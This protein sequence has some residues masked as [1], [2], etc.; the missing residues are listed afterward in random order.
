MAILIGQQRLMGH[1]LLDIPDSYFLYCL[2]PSL[3]HSDVLQALFKSPRR[4]V[5]SLPAESRVLGPFLNDVVS[6]L[7]LV[8]NSSAAGDVTRAVSLS[9]RFSRVSFTL[10]QLTEFAK[11]L[12]TQRKPCWAA[13]ENSR[14]SF[15]SDS[16]LRSACVLVSEGQEQFPGLHTDTETLN[17]THGVCVCV[18]SQPEDT[19]VYTV[20][21]C[22]TGL[23]RKEI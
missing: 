7:S 17:L 4:A 15:H 3:S 13:V 6:L 12:I 22:L 19:C 2:G 11:S 5:A 21:Y 16:K 10:T 8:R 23:N 9:C 1:V 14:V 20:N 18:G